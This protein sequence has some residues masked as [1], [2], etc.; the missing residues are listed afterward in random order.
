MPH[1]HISKKV[2]VGCKKYK[3]Y[4]PNELERIITK[5]Q[6]NYFSSLVIISTK[7]INTHLL[8]RLQTSNRLHFNLEM[9]K[10][11]N[12]Y[13]KKSVWHAKQTIS[14]PISDR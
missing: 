9:I 5:F 10:L 6:I 2:Y 14:G 7:K 11:L 13:K 8:L 12:F 3:F 4:N 1:Q